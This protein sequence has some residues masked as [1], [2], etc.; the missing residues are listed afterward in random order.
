[1]KVKKIAVALLATAT[2]AGTM[3]ALPVSANAVVA[4]YDTIILPIDEDPYEFPLRAHIYTENS[5]GA[6]FSG[7][8][9]DYT[10]YN[11]LGKEVPFNTYDPSME[12]FNPGTAATF[13]DTEFE[14]ESFSMPET[15]DFWDADY[16]IRFIEDG[17][18]KDKTNLKSVSLNNGLYSIG[19]QAFMGC[20]KLTGIEI[21]ETV[22]S[23][24]E[25][26]FSGCI[27][28]KTVSIPK[29]VKKI[30]RSTFSNCYR[31]QTVYYSGKRSDWDKLVIEP[32]NYYL[33][34]AEV[35]CSEPDIIL[36]DV[37]MDGKITIADVTA[38]QRHLSGGNKL[39]GDQ[40]IAADVDKN[41]R[42]NI[43]DVTKLQRYLSGSIASL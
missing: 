31:I 33:K 5:N 10:L 22:V 42:V 13:R 36:G 37:N 35:I 43:S 29:S 19:Y 39:T 28:L 3:L 6:S 40:L 8:I 21:P 38:I 2:A 18:F 14:G 32:G 15:I 12:K 26:A 7:V 9:D 20:R 4:K 41:G 17:A 24:E 16:Q 27:G 23:V 34:R 25:E 11:H 30:E 1:M